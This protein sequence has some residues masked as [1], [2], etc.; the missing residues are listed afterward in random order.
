M[1]QQSSIDIMHK[2]RTQEKLLKQKEHSH[3]LRQQQETNQVRTVSW[4]NH[5]YVP[6]QNRLFQNEKN[7]DFQKPDLHFGRTFLL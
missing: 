4:A 7:H 1:D 5:K 3:E 2:E 6:L